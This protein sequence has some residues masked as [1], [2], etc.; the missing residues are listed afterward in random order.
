MASHDF[1]SI[2][3]NKHS[4]NLTVFGFSISTSFVVNFKQR[5][6][7]TISNITLST[8][9]S[10]PLVIKRPV[11]TF[12]NSLIKLALKPTITI[13]IKKPTIV[14]TMRQLIKPTQTI[15]IK[16]PVVVFIMHLFSKI[17]SW[18]VI[19]KSPKIVFSPIIAR[20]HALWEYDNQT[21]SALD[22]TTLADLDYSVVP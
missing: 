21:L 22:S 10:F 15:V 3:K 13:Q 14:A 1:I 8:D 17:P 12:V 20:F 19:V 11:F 4:F 7:M 5:I 9:W 2:L 16:A 18:P 6:R